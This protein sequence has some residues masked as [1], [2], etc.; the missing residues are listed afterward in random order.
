V[1]IPVYSEIAKYSDLGSPVVLTLPEE[2]PVVKLYNSLA[3]SVDEEI[4]KIT[5][6]SQIPH[7]RYET[8]SSLVI[9]RTPDGKEKKIKALELRKSCNCALCVEEFSGK[10]LIKEDSIREDVYPYKIEPKGNYAVAIIWSDGHKSSIYPYERL[11][12]P[13]IKEYKRGEQQQ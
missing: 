7:V 4:S 6:T 1:A 10:P 5:A 13:H 11:L 2:H 3:V 9:V 8:G 12:S